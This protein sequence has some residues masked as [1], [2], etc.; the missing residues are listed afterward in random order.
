M[1]FPLSLKRSA[2]YD[3]FVDV[4]LVF[5]NEGERQVAQGGAPLLGHEF[6]GCSPDGDD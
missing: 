4:S 2:D 3:A 6:S 5:A 1:D